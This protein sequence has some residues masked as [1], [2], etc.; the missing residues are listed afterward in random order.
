MV[1]LNYIYFQL[2]YVKENAKEKKALK[3]K[4]SF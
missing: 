1:K 4:F 2:I 3:M